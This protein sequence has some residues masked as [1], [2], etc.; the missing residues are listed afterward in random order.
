MTWQMEIIK[1]LGKRKAWIR[2]DDDLALLV[3]FTK[4]KTDNEM[5]AAGQTLTP[6]LAIRSLQP[7]AMRFENF[8]IETETKAVRLN[9]NGGNA[10][11]VVIVEKSDA[12]TQKTRKSFKN[13]H[14][15][16]KEFKKALK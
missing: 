2:I 10:V 15:A 1:K 6:D 5:I 4:D 8:K 16:A 12:G 9:R 3:Q 14:L 11:A 7:K 13:M